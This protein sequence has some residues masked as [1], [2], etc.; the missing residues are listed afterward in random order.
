M[1]N[2]EVVWSE[3]ESRDIEKRASIDKSKKSHFSMIFNKKY[4][5]WPKMPIKYRI[6]VL[7]L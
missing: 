2:S 6:H 4:P 1:I 3:N 5:N 7:I